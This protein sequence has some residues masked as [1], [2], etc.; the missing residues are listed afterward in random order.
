MCVNAVFHFHS[1]SA[2][3]LILARSL[4]TTRLIALVNVVWMCL[5]G[6]VTTVTFK[7]ASS[8]VGC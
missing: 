1:D 2:V 7:L 3:K 4:Q 6:V 5:A 8:K